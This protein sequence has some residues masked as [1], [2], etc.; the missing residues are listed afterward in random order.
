MNGCDLGAQY[1]LLPGN[2]Q[3]DPGLV[4]WMV[5]W[6]ENLN[7]GELG[8]SG[9]RSLGSHQ[10]V[11]GLGMWKELGMGSIQWGPAWQTGRLL[12]RKLWNGVSVGC[13]KRGLLGDYRMG[14]AGGGRGVLMVKPGNFCHC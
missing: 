3:T 14:S 12:S 13:Q 10:V 6:S 1:I 2:L 5:L 7:G 8:A 4:K 11:P 9:V